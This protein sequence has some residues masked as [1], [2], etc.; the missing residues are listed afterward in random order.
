MH[1]SWE[2]GAL[3]GLLQARHLVEDAPE[4]P[5]ITLGIVLLPL[6]LEVN[7]QHICCRGQRSIHMSQGSKVNTHGLHVEWIM[8]SYHFRRDVVWCAQDG[9]GLLVGRREHFGNTEV[10]K[11]HNPLLSQKHVGR[12]QVSA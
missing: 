11:L 1:Q 2:V 4:C 10:S 7:G 8:I 3:K 12:L 5:D 6:T 9:V